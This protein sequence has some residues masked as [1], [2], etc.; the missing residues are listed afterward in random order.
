MKNKCI[1]IGAN[2]FLGS[3]LSKKLVELD[4]VVYAVYNNYNTNIPSKCNMV[5]INNLFKV[6][7]NVD[8][9]FFTAGSYKDTIEKNIQTNIFLLNSIIDN[10]TNAKFIYVSSVSVYGNNN[11]VINEMSAFNNPNLYGQSK[12]C[13]EYI[14]KKCL[15]YGIIRFTYLYGPYLDNNSFIPNLIYQLKNHNK[16]NLHGNGTR[17]Q[18]YLYIDDAVDLCLKVMLIQENNIF[19]GATGKSYTN[20]EVANILLNYFD[21]SEIFYNNQD[22]GISNFFDPSFTK[23]RLNWNNKISLE[24]GLKRMLL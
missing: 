11:T 13:A 15:S 9:I 7:D 24:E 19:L 12:I 3:A 10:Y 2:G 8:Y 4:Y 18:D 5:N 17:A 22:N 1:V 21:N 20:N 16:I 6:V 14:I 23:L